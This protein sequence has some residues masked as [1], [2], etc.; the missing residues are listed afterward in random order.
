MAEKLGR[1]NFVSVGYQRMQRVGYGQAEVERFRA[2][3]RE[4]VVPLAVEIR[5]RAGGEA[6]RR[7]ADVVG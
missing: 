5:A 2:Q 4:L 7:A 6:G 1:E 3:V